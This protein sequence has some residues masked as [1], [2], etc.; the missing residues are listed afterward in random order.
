MSRMSAEIARRSGRERA[1]VFR[2]RRRAKGLRL[3]Q[4][5]VPDVTTPEFRAEARRQSVA[6]ACSA[7][8][9]DDQAFIDSVSIWSELPDEDFAER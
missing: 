2:A 4:F 3:V 9:A 5:W 7:A 6:A 8:A 1:R